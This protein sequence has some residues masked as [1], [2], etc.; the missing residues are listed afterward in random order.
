VTHTCTHSLTIT[1]TYSHTLT[2]AWHTAR[3]AWQC[4]GRVQGGGGLSH[5][6]GNQASNPVLQVVRLDMQNLAAPAQTQHPPSNKQAIKYFSQCA[7]TCKQMKGGNTYFVVMWAPL[8]WESSRQ[9]AGGWGSKH[10]RGTFHL[11]MGGT[12]LDFKT[13]GAATVVQPPPP[14]LAWRLTPGGAAL[15]LPAY[16][17]LTAQP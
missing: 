8:A 5:P 14:A 12:L 10:K 11:T 3:A 16:L 4:S 1:C 2:R 9:A 17:L 7:C 13:A 6:P 15:P